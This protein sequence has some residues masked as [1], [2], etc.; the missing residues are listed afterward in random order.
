MKKLSVFVLTALVGL[1]LFSCEKIGT[2][3]Q[4]TEIDFAIMGKMHNDGL[5]SILRGFQD[6]GTN[7]DQRQ[8]KAE[9]QATYI[10]II[11]SRAIS[12]V[13]EETDNN[14]EAVSIAKDL[15]DKFLDD[16][17]EY[18]EYKT[19]DN[20]IYT[21]YIQSKKMSAAF[22]AK[23]KDL[24]EIATDKDINL[25]SLLSRL[26]QLETTVRRSS[27]SADEKNILLAGISVAQES[28]QYWYDKGPEWL[29]TLTGES[30]KGKF[31]WKRVGIADIGGAISG[32]V[33]V[34]AAAL[35]GP[36]GWT[37]VIVGVAGSAAGAS[38]GDAVVQLLE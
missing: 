11:K 22:N 25:Q 37:A 10:T 31:S 24:N 1:F 33:R 20:T 13:K 8:T 14:A 12:Y 4:S 35:A 9:S 19:I 5:E 38:A 27:L 3:K 17:P 2:V 15:L 23:L 29:E 32:A 30:K 34:G 6:V 26:Q 7:F 28:Y 21:P 18:I 16:N 36:V